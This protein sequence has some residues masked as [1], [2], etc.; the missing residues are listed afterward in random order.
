M[1][2][3]NT[4]PNIVDIAA[5]SDDFQLLVRALTVTNLVHTVRAT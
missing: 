4:A 3:P 1:P 5:G 2:K